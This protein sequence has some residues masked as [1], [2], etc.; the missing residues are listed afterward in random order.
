ME[1]ILKQKAEFFKITSELVKAFPWTTKNNN[2]KFNSRATQIQ[3]IRPG[4]LQ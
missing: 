4:Y 3:S 2:N 1:I